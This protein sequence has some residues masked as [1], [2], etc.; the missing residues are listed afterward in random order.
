M[1]QRTTPLLG[2]PNGEVADTWWGLLY[3]MFNVSTIGCLPHIAQGGERPPVHGA[4]RGHFNRKARVIETANLRLS[5][6]VV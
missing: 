6:L 4:P 2:V 1:K 3:T 5:Y